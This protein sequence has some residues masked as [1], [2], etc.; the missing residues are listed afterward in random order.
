MLPNAALDN[1]IN[2]SEGRITIEKAQITGQDPV[3]PTTFPLGEFS[4]GVHAV[5][6][7]AA[8]KIWELRTGQSQ[9]V[10]IDYRLAAATL[11]SMAYLKV[12]GAKLEPRPQTNRFHETR[13][14]RWFF[15]H[16]GFPHL[17]QGAVK[18]LKCEA[19]FQ[20]PI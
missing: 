16:G 10:Q 7:L 15:G 14:H 11:Q 4:A 20:N 19:T 3:L 8:A 17:L 5:Y 6:G 2:L 9:T 18:L 12:D 1:L 13:D